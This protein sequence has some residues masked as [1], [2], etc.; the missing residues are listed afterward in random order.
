MREV[1]GVIRYCEARST[2]YARLPLSYDV[3][4]ARAAAPGRTVAIA[5]VRSFQ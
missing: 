1:P 2:M 4:A 3:G 5:A